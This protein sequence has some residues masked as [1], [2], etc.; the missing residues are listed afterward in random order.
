MDHLVRHTSVKLCRI[1]LPGIIHFLAAECACF[2]INSVNGH[3][4]L[5]I[6]AFTWTVIPISNLKTMT[7][8]MHPIKK[9][10]L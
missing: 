1:Y 8:E 6:L 5:F 2:K 4:M 3:H 10:C 7:F 9:S